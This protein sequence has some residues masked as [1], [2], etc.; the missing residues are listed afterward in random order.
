MSHEYNTLTIT[1]PANGDL[2][3]NQYY[4]VKINSSGNAVVI[5]T[6]G[7]KALGVLQND[8]DTA[9]QAAAIMVY[10]VSKVVAGGTIVC[11][12][13]VTFNSSG[14]AVKA[15]EETEAVIGRAM[16]SASSGETFNVFLS[17]EGSAANLE[18]LVALT[19]SA[20]YSST[21][22]YLAMKVHTVDGQFVKCSTAGEQIL[23]I[24]QD[25][26]ASAAVGT[27][28]CFGETT[29]TAGTGGVTGGDK[30][31][32]D[33]AG[34]LVTATAG[35]FIVGF[36]LEAIS[37]DATGQ[38]FLLSSASI[39]VAGQSL[40]DTYVWVGNGSNVAAAVAVSGDATLA[41]TGAL[42][43]A[44]DK[45]SAAK[46]ASTVAG[47][48]GCIFKSTSTPNAVTE[49]DV[50]I[51]NLVVGTT[52]D[53]GLLDMG[54]SAGNIMVDSGTAPASVAV[55]GDATLA[56]DG[57]LTIANDAVGVAKMSSTVAGS[58]GCIFK[59]TSTPDA[60]TELDVPTGNIIVGTS[61]DV[62]LLDMGATAGNIIVDSGTAPASVAVSGD[63][64]L[65]A[66][67]TLTLGKSFIRAAT[68]TWSVAQVKAGNVTPLVLLDF[69]AQQAAGTIAAGDAFIFHGLVANLYQG[70]AAYDQN[71]NSI[72]KYQTAGGGAT[73]SLTLA[74]W[75]NGGADG[76]C[77]TLKPVA[78]DVAIE[79]N[80]DVVWTMSASPFNA[81]GDR[82]LSVTCYYSV[83]TPAT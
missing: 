62:G 40:T 81:A 15:D 61:G 31:A 60:V 5:S 35:D 37:A 75:F 74:N 64:T 41:N 80:E 78:T 45:V 39:S 50:P 53:V 51:G 18:D 16:A 67:G 24:L 25:A 63:A 38:V 83:Y 21:G 73:L 44:N 43:I 14:A 19:A 66:A 8:P 27:I 47:S 20:D 52:N 29:A 12:D 59:S 11:N 77:T 57:A 22:Q 68:T 26:P 46:M 9:G 69:S 36:A 34:K 56:A 6:Q 7:D 82:L 10:G 79:I 28:K 3:S 58:D 72:I 55:S 49:L 4:G 54:A 71:E 1:R 42:T 17:H 23:G 65:A 30:L 76:A 13:P 33:S 48:D 2:S 32:T 70:A